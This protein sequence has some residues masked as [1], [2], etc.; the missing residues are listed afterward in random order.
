MYGLFLVPAVVCAV[1]DHGIPDTL[2]LRRGTFVLKGI[3]GPTHIEAM[4]AARV[5]HVICIC[6][7][8]DAGFEPDHESKALAD[9]GILFCR[10]SLKRAPTGD[11]FEMFRMVRNSLPPDAR[12]LV[13]CTDGNRAAAVVV[14]WLAVEKR[15]KPGEV[16]AVARTA[17]VVHKE[18]ENALKAYLKL[19][20]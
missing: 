11:D 3:P 17:G 15:I 5:T 7:D 18:T 10:V 9:A 6:R 13:H 1:L 2:E 19:A 16:M 20:P 12:V 8:G 4:K 14:A